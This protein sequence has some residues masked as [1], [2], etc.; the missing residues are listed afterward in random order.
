MNLLAR[1]VKVG[2]PG[3]LVV[4]EAVASELP[5][6]AWSLR[7]LEP[8]DLRGIEAPVRAFIVE[9]RQPPA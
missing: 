9:R 2:A 5:A 4:T 1:L 7:P 3:E 6:D 8:T